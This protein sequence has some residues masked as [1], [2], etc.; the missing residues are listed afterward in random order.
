VDVPVPDEKIRLL[1]AT[2][3]T[4]QAVQGWMQRRLAGNLPRT[5]WPWL[6]LGWLGALWAL[7]LAGMRV[8]TARACERCGGAACRRCDGAE[9]EL[10]GQCVNVFVRKGVVDARDRL[11]KEAQVR[12]HG[13]LVNVATR[14]LALVAGG[15]A[16]VFHGAP[17]RGALLLVAMLHGAFVVW[18]WRG[19]M[20]PP[21]PSPYV[22]AGKLVLAAPLGLA[23]WALAVRDAF[24]RTR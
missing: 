2:D 23:V 12:R 6:P 19:I 9:G 5:L 1:A 21:Q 20:P 15:A 22:L 7:A 3:G 16:Q 24:R 4:P 10:C 17:V 14:I 18:F 11:R 13:Q 8:R